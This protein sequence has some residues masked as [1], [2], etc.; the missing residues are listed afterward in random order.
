M[1]WPTSYVFDKAGEGYS[2]SNECGYYNDA[3]D[4]ETVI[5]VTPHIS[6]SL[7]NYITNVTTLFYGAH[8]TWVD[9][10]FDVE[11]NHSIYN[12]SGTISMDVTLKNYYNSTRV[13]TYTCDVIVKPY[14]FYQE[15]SAITTDSHWTPWGFTIV[16]SFEPCTACFSRSLSPGASSWITLSDISKNDRTGEW[17]TTLLVTFDDNTGATRTA[18]LTAQYSDFD[19]NVGEFTWAITQLQSGQTPQGEG[20][21]TVITPPMTVNSQ[22]HDNLTCD[23]EIENISASTLVL[24]SSYSWIQPRTV[25]I[26]HSHDNV[27]TAHFDVSYNTAYEGREGSFF[28]RGIDGTGDYV[29]ADFYITQTA[30]VRIES[31]YPIWR[32][33]KYTLNNVSD[34]Y[35]DYYLSCN[36]GSNYNLRSYTNNGKNSI[37]INDIAADHLYDSLQLVRPDSGHGE[38]VQS[39]TA[40][41][42]FN[43]YKTYQG[44]TTLAE[45]YTVYNDWS[46]VD[47]DNTE[48]LIYLSDPIA[49]VL[50]YRQLFLFTT[51]G[52]NAEV[53]Q[54]I[55]FNSLLNNSADTYGH[56]TFVQDLSKAAWPGDFQPEEFNNDFLLYY[57]G[58]FNEGGN[59]TLN[60]NNV[61]RFN[62]VD[63]CKRY[64]LYYLNARGG[65]DSLLCDGKV[66]RTDNYTNN[67]FEQNYSNIDKSNW[68]VVNYR[69]DIKTTWQLNT[70]YITDA[71]AEKM[72][73]V[74]GSTKMYL[75][76]LGTGEIWSVIV[77][78]KKCEYKTYRNQQRKSFIYTIEVEASQ[79]MWRG[80]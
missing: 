66:M 53:N 51:Y 18:T 75:H 16:S 23:F 63:S 69:K 45:Q 61:Y 29:M 32:Q 40:V 6:P 26:T 52:R 62:V 72:H 24:M 58:S 9:L 27:Y 67:T 71:Q 77:N 74:L 21:I 76:D 17:V 38:F 13:D 14:Y 39:N 78:S 33:M 3:Y 55:Y 54:S 64:C 22:Q 34:E 36:D 10:V 68:G 31:F 70:R 7:A 65:W 59:M 2:F 49:F 48:S 8:N 43:L 4:Y 19:D 79:K 50:D 37:E 5:N 1:A 25:Q 11:Q 46:Y 47:Y 28:I 41:K 35:I 80:Q 56:Y 60:Y 44:E 12:I 57:H 42:Q 30:A 15:S 73:N 20:S